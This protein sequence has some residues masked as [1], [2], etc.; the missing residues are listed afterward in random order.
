MAKIPEMIFYFSVL[1]EYFGIAAS[2]ISSITLVDLKDNFSE[3]DYIFIDNFTTKSVSTVPEPTFSL[4]LLA[5]GIMGAGS[6]IKRKI[7]HFKSPE[8]HL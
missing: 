4:S 6:T 3:G 2:G 1:G 8:K 7:K 5:F